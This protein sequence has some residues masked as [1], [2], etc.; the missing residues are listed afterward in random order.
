MTDAF[1]SFSSGN[2]SSFGM[3][4]SLHLH[5][6]QRLGCRCSLRMRCTSTLRMMSLLA[7][8]NS[9]ALPRLPPQSLSPF[10]Y[11]LHLAKNVCKPSIICKIYPHTPFLHPTELRHRMYCV[12]CSQLADS[13]QP[14]WLR[15]MQCIAHMQETYF[16][17]R[18]AA[19]CRCH[20]A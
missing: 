16:C 17:D 3:C 12:T 2:L 4:C 7:N 14:W 9:H 11:A 18:T 5:S 8:Q 20:M 10:R 13:I 15:L 1:I 19:L 6:Q